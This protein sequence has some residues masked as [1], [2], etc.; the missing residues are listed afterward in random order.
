MEFT[1]T[2]N[3][4]RMGMWCQQCLTHTWAAASDPLCPMFAGQTHW[5]QGV[6]RHC[7]FQAVSSGLGGEAAASAEV[8][9]GFNTWIRLLCRHLL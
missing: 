1:V 4:P 7:M 2:H 3:Q 5:A 8:Q 9:L 6:C